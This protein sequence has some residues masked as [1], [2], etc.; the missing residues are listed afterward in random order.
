MFVLVCACVWVCVHQEKILWKTSTSLLSL[1]T[2][3]IWLILRSNRVVNGA[4]QLYEVTP[5]AKNQN[6]FIDL[7]L[8][9][10]RLIVID[11]M[12]ITALE[13]LE[14]SHP[15]HC[16]QSNSNHFS[17]RVLH[18]QTNKLKCQKIK[19]PAIFDNY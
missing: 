12:N 7:F 19:F 14:K 8:F 2:N 18:K 6:N 13:L 17:N 11:V 3:E 5:E 4:C 15:L 16:F 1:I 10:N 9:I